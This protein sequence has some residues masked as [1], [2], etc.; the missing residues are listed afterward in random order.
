MLLLLFKTTP[1]A[2]RVSFRLLP[3]GHCIRAG[4]TPTGAQIKI[5]LNKLKI[6]HLAY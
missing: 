5:A 1:V 4:T 3:T 2:P 6:Y